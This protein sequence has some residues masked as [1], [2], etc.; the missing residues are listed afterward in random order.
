MFGHLFKLLRGGTGP[1]SRS[2]LSDGVALVAQRLV[3]GS[4]WLIPL[5]VAASVSTAFLQSQE[6]FAVPSLGTFIF[7]SV[8]ILGLYLFVDIS[9]NLKDLV[10][11]ILLEAYYVGARNFWH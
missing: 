8:I 3:S 2:G 10:W 1:Y 9:G 7:N 4:L 6:R 5:S 11:F